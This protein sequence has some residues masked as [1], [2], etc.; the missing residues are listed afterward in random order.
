MSFASSL[1]VLHDPS[2]ANSP[3]I[4]GLVAAA[5]EDPS[6]VAAAVDEITVSVRDDPD[7]ALLRLF[8]LVEVLNEVIRYRKAMPELFAEVLRKLR[9]ALEWI[10]TA[11]NAA[12]YQ[13]AYNPGTAGGVTIAL[14]FSR[15]A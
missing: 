10:A 15:D 7:L 12:S 1:R 8:A 4:D 14:V 6:G 13:L 9:E 11:L 5:L 3:D 2:V